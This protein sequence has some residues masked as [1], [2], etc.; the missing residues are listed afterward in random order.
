MAIVTLLTDMGY[1]D[2]Y[3]AMAKG[4]LIGGVKDLQLV[5][6]SHD[7]SVTSDQ[8]IASF[9]LR[10]VVPQFPKG[11][12]HII[13]VN[14]TLDFGSRHVVFEHKGHYF[15]GSDSGIFFM[16]LGEHP[17]RVFDITGYAKAHTTF[18]LMDIFVPAVIDI[19]QG[20]GLE[21]IGSTEIKLVEKTMF[22]PTVEPGRIVGSI[23]YVDVHGNL[24]TNITRNLFEKVRNG[25]KFK[26][27]VRSATYSVSKI[28]NNYNEVI[29]GEIVAVINY[30]GL[31]EIA[32]HNANCAKMLGVEVRSSMIIEFSDIA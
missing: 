9:M 4:K 10:N 12:I 23:L 16:F 14:T 27:Y 2:P 13:S 3:L 8:M 32:M 28:S 15:V 26:I 30:S 20:K 24:I 29:E 22:H 7:P 11:T 21:E 17:Q 19:I 31:I 6:T 18:P 5:D 1:R 25:R